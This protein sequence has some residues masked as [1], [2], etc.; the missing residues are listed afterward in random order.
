MCPNGIR[1]TPTASA[2]PLTT[3]SGAPLRYLVHPY[4]IQCTPTV[5]GAPLRCPVHPY[6][7][8]CTPTVSS[9]S[10]RYPV[11]TYGIQYT[12]TVCSA[13]LRYPV[14]PYGI[15]WTPTVSSAPSLEIPNLPAALHW[16]MVSPWKMRIWKKVSISRIR[17]GCKTRLLDEKFAKI[18]GEKNMG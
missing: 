7:I 13:P 14:H 8:Q 1:Y 5:Y 2:A 3:A 12:P 11:H 4:G 17:S 9:A 15:Q 16:A 6:G 18:L 10:L